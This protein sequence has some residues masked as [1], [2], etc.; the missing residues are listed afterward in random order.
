MNHFIQEYRIILDNIVRIEN[1]S[2]FT[3]EQDMP[4]DYL[5]EHVIDIV[6]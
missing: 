5:Q 3:A 2:F 6:L 4:S 1:I